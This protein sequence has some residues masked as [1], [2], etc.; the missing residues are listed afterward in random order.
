[1]TGAG[2]C[3]SWRTGSAAGGSTGRRTFPRSASGDGSS[4]WTCPALAGPGRCLAGTRSRRSRTRSRSCASSSACLRSCMP[5]IRWAGRWRCDSP[6]ATPAWR[7]R[8]CWWPARWTS[9]PRR[10]AGATSAATC[11]I[12]PRRSLRPTSRCSRPRCRPPVPCGGRSGGGRRCGGCCCGPICTGRRRCPP[13]ASPCSWTARVP[14]ACFPPPWPSGGC[15]QAK[16]PARSGARSWR[17]APTTTPSLRCPTSRPSPGRFRPLRPLCSKGPGTCSCS[18]GRTP[19]TPNSPA[20]STACR[21]KLR[22][23]ALIRLCTRQHAAPARLIW[24]D[25]PPA[26]QRPMRGDPDMSATTARLERRGLK[27]SEITRRLDGFYCYNVSVALWADAVANRLAGPALYLLADELAEV[28]QDA[29][30]ASARLAD[31]LGDLGGAVTADPRELPGRFPADFTIP[32]NCA[33]PA[34]ILNAAAPNLRAVI[35]AYEDFLDQ[36]RGKDDVSHHLVTKL[37]GKETHRLADLEAA[38]EPAG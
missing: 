33:D 30:A 25:T 35:D 15:A 10:W 13:A 27:A 8:S 24:A 17:S 6:P 37:L 38:R 20:S 23:C 18:S 14:A 3:S 28:A 4:R 12:T 22:P 32:A 16:A 21:A 1:M 29:R 31:R 5:A 36:V 11:D 7:G 2:T 9:S 19:S 26:R 34:A